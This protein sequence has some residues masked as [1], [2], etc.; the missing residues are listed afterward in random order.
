MAIG[1]LQLPTFLYRLYDAD[2]V[3][4]YVGITNN[5]ATRMGRHSVE[6]S[7][8]PEVAGIRVEVCANR[9]EAEAA[10]LAAIRDERPVWNVDGVPRP[11]RPRGWDLTDPHGLVRDS[12]VDVRLPATFSSEAQRKNALRE[13]HR[14]MIRAG[15]L[16]PA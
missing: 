12:G 9:Q 1:Q 16:V 6:K 11:P 13:V 4:L 7:W 5:L 15:L 8:W 2:G 10:E 3:L 14:A